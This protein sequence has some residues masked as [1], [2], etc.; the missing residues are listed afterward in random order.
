LKK[1]IYVS[2]LLI[3]TPQTEQLSRNAAGAIKLETAALKIGEVL[4]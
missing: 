3:D 1:A 2:E 4:V